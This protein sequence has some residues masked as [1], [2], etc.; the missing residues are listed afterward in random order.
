M[1]EGYGDCSV[2]FFW[3]FSISLKLFKNKTLKNLYD[4][5]A[6]GKTEV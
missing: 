6:E 3:Q 4:I 1:G 5:F 2:P